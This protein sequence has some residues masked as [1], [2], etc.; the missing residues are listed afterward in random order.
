MILKLEMQCSIEI[1]ARHQTEVSF[2]HPKL[3][4]AKAVRLFDFSSLLTLPR[5]RSG[6][7][8]GSTSPGS[9]RTCLTLK[10][11]AESSYKKIRSSVFK[12]GFVSFRL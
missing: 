5:G 7:G 9:R 12:D 10:S 1:S 2:L 11:E 6:S 8:G 4:L 3:M